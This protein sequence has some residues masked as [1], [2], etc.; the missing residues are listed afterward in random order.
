MLPRDFLAGIGE[1]DVVVLSSPQ[2]DHK[3]R[4]TVFLWNKVTKVNRNGCIVLAIVWTRGKK[5]QTGIGLLDRRR[6]GTQHGR[7]SKLWQW[8]Y[9]SLAF[10]IVAL[11]LTRLKFTLKI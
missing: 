7:L 5:S 11:R 6:R 1:I 9:F 4:A 2:G 8:R 10:A 3:G